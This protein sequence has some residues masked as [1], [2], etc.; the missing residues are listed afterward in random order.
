M[1]LRAALTGLLEQVDGEFSP[2]LSQRL[3]LDSYA[4]KLVDNAVIFPLIECGRLSAFVAMYCNDPDG[5]SAYITMVATAPTAR[6]K[7]TAAGLVELSIQH[8]RSRG[9]SQVALEVYRSNVA[10]LKLYNK[11]GFVVARENPHSLFL[12]FSL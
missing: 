4:N 6:G 12:S 3:S 5:K 8:A 2:P 1:L 11:L 7:G 9:F 10:A